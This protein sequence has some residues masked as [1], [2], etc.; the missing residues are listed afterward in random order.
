[1]PAARQDPAD[2]GILL[3]GGLVEAELGDAE[4]DASRDGDL[5]GR[6]RHGEG[7]TDTAED[8]LA[9]DR[10]RTSLSTAASTPTPP[11]THT[12]QAICTW[13]TATSDVTD[14]TRR[15]T[16]VSLL[17]VTVGAKVSVMSAL[18]YASKAACWTRMNIGMRIVPPSSTYT[19]MRSMYGVAPLRDG[20]STGERRRSG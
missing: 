5:G 10:G 16:G 14:G 11:S 2:R 19:A 3:G 4:V 17:V 12:H 18:A 1:M 20:S 13:P 7:I 9:H 6:R 8:L 15:H